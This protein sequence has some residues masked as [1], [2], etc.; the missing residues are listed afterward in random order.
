MA[1]ENIG[2]IKCPFTQR[3][4]AVRSDKRGKLYYYS[5]A[6][7][8]APNLAAGQRF[9][10]DNMKPIENFSVNATAAGYPPAIAPLTEQVEAVPAEKPLTQQ[11][12]VAP[13]VKRKSLLEEFGL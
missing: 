6:G 12:E 9:I 2:V 10:K 3:L 7:K 5:E 13:P 1:N 4:S 11:V 8:I